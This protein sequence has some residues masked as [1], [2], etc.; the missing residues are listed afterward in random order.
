MAR[1]AALSAGAVPIAF[2]LANAASYALLVVAAHRMSSSDYGK[3]SSLLGLLLITTIPMLALQTVTARRAATGAGA[4]GIVRGSVEVAAISTA[5]MCAL[6]PAIAVF[7]HL[8]SVVGIVL[9][10]ATI[11]ATALLGTAMGAAQGLR[12]FTR[13]AALLLT[14]TGGRSVGGLIGLL[15][16]HTTDA[17]L[18]GVLIGTSAAAIGVIAFGRPLRSY[19]SSLIDRDRAGVVHETFYAAYAHGTFLVLTSLDVLLARHVLSSA[20]AGVYS[21]GSVV[22]RATVWLPQ[23]VILILFASLAQ[24]QRA[25]ARRSVITVVALAAVCAAGAAALG[26]LVVTVVGGSKYHELDD[27]VWLYAFLGGLLAVLQLAMLAGLAQR[28]A[29][30]ATLLWATIVVDVAVVVAIGHDV[31]PTQ[32][33]ATLLSVTSASAL[34]A[35]WLMLRQPALAAGQ[36][37]RVNV[38]S[39]PAPNLAATPDGTG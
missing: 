5:L 34:V 31:T 6:S 16:G 38:G 24:Q 39:S 21:V 25:A 35:L 19:R 12:R 32:L 7:L 33:V 8:H 9:V 10:A 15:I 36:G 27:T 4:N 3:L 26:P 22:T 28:S 30:R 29:R 37:P 18:V 23:S 11:P 2:L 13:L 20:D 1:R 14:S 17:T